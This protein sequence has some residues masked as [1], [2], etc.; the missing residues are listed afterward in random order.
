MNTLELTEVLNS[1]IR[2][3]SIIGLSFLLFLIW[4]VI[5]TKNSQEKPIAFVGLIIE[6]DIALIFSILTAVRAIIWNSG[7]WFVFGFVL[8]FSIFFLMAAFSL[9]FRQSSLSSRTNNRKG[10]KEK[11]I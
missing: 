7:L 2:V 9:H 1:V 8:L 11:V 6:S 5:G 10:K 3:L 4:T